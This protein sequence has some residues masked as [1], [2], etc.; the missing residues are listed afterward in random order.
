MSEK[1]AKTKQRIVDCALQLFSVKGFVGT[2]IH[3]VMQAAELTK[4][5]IYAHFRSKEE[6]WNAAYEEAV[7][8]WKE[9]VFRGVD[10]IED[11]LERVAT[12]V[13][14]DLMDYVAKEVFVGGCFFLNCLMEVSGQFDAMTRRIFSGFTGFSRLL[15]AWLQEADVRG[16]LRPGVDTRE[17]AD[18]IITNLNGAAALW[19]ASRDRRLLE[20]SVRQTRALLESLRQP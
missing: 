20:I 4:G 5:G 2:S 18:Y 12:V 7:H 13:E 17:V 10:K 6:L 3:D 11:P 19:A 8:I 9:I 16:L 15:A 14:Q 1:G